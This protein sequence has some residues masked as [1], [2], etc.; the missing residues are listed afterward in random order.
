MAK[1]TRI[2][3]ALDNILNEDYRVLGSGV[4]EPGRSFIATLDIWL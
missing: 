4:N 3:L 2:T 1:D